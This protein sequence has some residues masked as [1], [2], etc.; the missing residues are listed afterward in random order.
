MKC[1]V[2][3]TSAY[4]VFI[5]VDDNE[6][7]HNHAFSKHDSINYKN[8]KAITLFYQDVPIYN[9]TNIKHPKHS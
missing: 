2:L 5:L 6:K 1:S 3:L 9:V 4:E 8:I 7:E